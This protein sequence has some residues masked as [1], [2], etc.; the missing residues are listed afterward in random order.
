MNINELYEYITAHMT[1]EEALKKFL[2]SGL[3]TYEKLKFD[4]QGEAVHPVFVM[5]YAA[6][7]MGWNFAIEKDGGADVRGMTIG[8]KEY[9]DK[10]FSPKGNPDLK[11]PEL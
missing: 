1:P 4:S 11:N 10:I 8:T 2:E 9:F 3:L 7:D 6:M 5:C